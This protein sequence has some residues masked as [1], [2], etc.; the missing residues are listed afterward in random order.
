MIDAIVERW[1]TIAV[2]VASLAISIIAMV[3]A[4][5]Y[6]VRPYSVCFQSSSHKLFDY[7]IEPDSSHEE[8]R[9]VRLVST[10]VVLWNGGG[11]ALVYEHHVKEPIRL[12][13]GESDSIVHHR[14]LKQSDN[15]ACIIEKV[16]QRSV[17]V[18]FSH[19]DRNDGFVVELFHDSE[20]QDPKIDGVILD[21]P[22]GFRNLGTMATGSARWLRRAIMRQSYSAI[23]FLVFGILLW[24]YAP[25]EVTNGGRLLVGMAI[26]QVAGVLLS[27]WNR[28]KRY[29]STLYLRDEG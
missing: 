10:K 15:I 5:V 27:F 3:F 22:K 21:H 18:T 7:R 14:I 26:G 6:R 17:V 1:F 13:F 20:W 2:G 11:R 23:F 8:P 25:H 12:S 19:L 16:D 9:T 24:T 28:R 29:P 4:I